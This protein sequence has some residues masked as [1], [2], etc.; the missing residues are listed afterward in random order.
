LVIVG[1]VAALFRCHRSQ[2]VFPAHLLKLIA[3]SLDARVII[4]TGA[5]WTAAVRAGFA[6]GGGTAE[7]VVEGVEV[8]VEVAVGGVEGESEGLTGGWGRGRFLGVHFATSPSATVPA[9]TFSTFA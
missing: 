3:P 7:D 5:V 6:V 1:G 8:G 4:T 2:L 9:L